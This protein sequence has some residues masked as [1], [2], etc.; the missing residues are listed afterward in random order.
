ML[1]AEKRKQ[2][3]MDEGN[4][5]DVRECRHVIKEGTDTFNFHDLKP[6]VWQP[7]RREF[8]KKR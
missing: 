8:Q 4:P 1:L 2:E 7:I 6:K 5:N 3:R